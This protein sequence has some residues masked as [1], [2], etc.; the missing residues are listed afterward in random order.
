MTTPDL[1]GTA[2]E[3]SQAKARY[4]LALDTKDWKALADLMDPDIE[5]DVRADDTGV[6]V[7]RERDNA[8]ELIRTRSTR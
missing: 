8:I 6:P 5:L 1:L 2:H 7:I 4:C 3:L